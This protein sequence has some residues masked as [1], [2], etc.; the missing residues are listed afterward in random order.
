MAANNNLQQTYLPFSNITDKQA[1]EEKWYYGDSY[2]NSFK[3]I[4]TD[5]FNEKTEYLQ[6]TSKDIK[7]FRNNKIIPLKTETNDHGYSRILAQWEG[8]VTEVNKE[9]FKAILSND[10]EEE[11]HAEF[12]K[13]E[14]SPDDMKLIQVNNIFYWSVG[15]KMTR[16]QQRKNM[17]SILFRR[18]PAWKSFDVNKPSKKARELFG[19]FNQPT[20]ES[21]TE[22]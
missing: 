12:S 16:T 2:I 21:S 11:Y 4:E 13:S 6:T 8:C 15:Y 1:Q 14:V 17:D 3:Q 20:S 5:K 18:L 9:T 19:F 10:K 22:G 7:S